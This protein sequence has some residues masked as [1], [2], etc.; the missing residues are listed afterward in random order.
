MRA[1]PFLRRFRL[2]AASSLVCAA[3]SGCK[4]GGEG[5]LYNP[6][7]ASERAPDTF[8]AKFETTAGDFSVEC[9][10][11]WAP[12]GADRFY[13]LV[14]IGFYDD[15]AFF[16]VVKSPRPFV[17]QWGIHGNPSVSARWV[18]ARI[19]PDPAVV[20]NTRGR[21]TFAMA[22]EPDTRTTQVFINYGDNRALDEKG[23]APVCEVVDDGMKVVEALN[24]EYGEGPT[25]EQG[26]IQSKG[27]AFLKQAHPKLDYVKRATLQDMQALVAPSATPAPSGGQ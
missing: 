14:K 10:R 7:Q 15:V 17:V 26:Q 6:E 20:S 13:N 21:L 12:N 19:A 4:A 2:L 18:D 1:A 8:R 24:G 5:P 23:F 3:F 16:R 25:G 27:N 9:H 11:E 22:G